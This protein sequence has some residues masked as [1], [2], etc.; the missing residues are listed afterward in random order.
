M[1]MR[2]SVIDFE[3]GVARAFHA[4]ATTG[5]LSAAAKKL[6]LTQPTLTRQVAALEAQ[7]GVTLFDRVGKRLL[8]TETGRSLLAHVQQ[9]EEAAVALTLAAS[10][11]NSG[12]KGVVSISATDVIATYIVPLALPRIRREY[13]DITVSVIAS[14]S[15]SDLRRREADIALRHVRPR[16]PELIGK[17][18]LETE[19]YFYAS[20]EWVKRHGMPRA[21]ED[22]GKA[23][24][25]GDDDTGRY[26]AHLQKLG[27]PIKA[28]Q[29]RLVSSN[30]VV[31]WELVKRGHGIGL[32]MREVAAMCPE[33]VQ[34]LPKLRPTPVPVWLV[35]HRE[36]QTSHR[37]R[38]VF[39]ILD[40]E[41]A[42]LRLR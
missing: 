32:M 42:K 29:F 2:K 13:P 28:E 30:V 35:T 20:V 16:E 9:M 6:G 7:L 27:L 25:L 14:N 33:V 19:A 4:T 17:R 34:V 1:Y 41:I 5:S 36:I 21:P 10:G 24:W 15:I 3:W 38:A 31:L 8:L 12:A 23:E 18:V 40:D 26:A 22:V 37:I 39:D 11:R